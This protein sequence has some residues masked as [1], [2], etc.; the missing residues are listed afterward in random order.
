[1]QKGDK[2]AVVCCS[3]GQKESYKE[4]I[5]LLYASLQEIG[6]CPVFS[7]FI[8]ER[9]TVAAGTAKER[10]SAFMDFYK[11]KTIKAVFDISGGDMANEILPYLDF[12]MI[13]ANQ[14]KF[15]GY[16]DLTTVINAIY[17][18]TGNTSI[19]YQVRN[20]INDDTHIQYKN[21]KNMVIDGKMDLFEFQYEFVQ[22]GQL[23]G[24]VIGGNIRCFLKLAGTPYFPDTKDKV[25]L[26]ESM[27]GKLPQI[28]TYLSQLEQI[29]VFDNVT[30]IILG[31]FT[32]MEKD[33][34]M[35]DTASL[36]K[37]F[38]KS[39]MPIVKTS[40]IGHGYN[41]KAIVIGK[42]IVLC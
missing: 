25:L 7:S 9:D 22:G 14:K 42:E 31:T 11:D 30:G 29:G 6:L 16:S 35:P 34:S 39:G 36:V 12:D 13:A 21:F 37:K 27:G 19:L 28:V 3:N 4:K 40:D 15:W 5:E 1:M 33:D 38:V 24:T 17:T 18:K 20:I 26:L 8:Y 32:E 10:A 2:V 23:G 41:S